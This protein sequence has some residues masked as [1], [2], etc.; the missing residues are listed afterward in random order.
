MAGKT[1]KKRNK[2]EVIGIIKK[3]LDLS[4]I[5]TAYRDLYVQHVKDLLAPDILSAEEYQEIIKDRERLSRLPGRINASMERG[6]WKSVKEYSRRM[7]DLHT[8]V[9]KKQDLYEIG[10]AVFDDNTI[11]VSPFSPGLYHVA[12]IKLDD[13]PAVRRKTIKK[14][15]DIISSDTSLK[16][17]Y[18]SRQKYYSSINLD[19]SGEASFSA[20]ETELSEQAKQAL[21]HGDIARLEE[22][23]EKI[24]EMHNAGADGENRGDTF[25]TGA[26][27]T[28]SGRSFEFSPETL[29]KAEE[30]GLARKQV[31][32]SPE[33]A[34][35]YRNALHPDYSNGR[36]IEWEK[37]REKNPWFKEG[38]PEGLKTRTEIYA[39]HI[40]IN[41]C[42]TRHLPDFVKEDILVEDFPET[43][44]NLGGQ[45]SS[46]MK[47]LG[48]ETR[49]GL[50][51]L[52]IEKALSASA[53]KIIRDELGLDP[54]QFKL[55]CIPSDIY[56]RLGDSMEWGKQKL[57][58]HF[59]GYEVLRNGRFNALVGGDARFGGIYDLVSIGR[60]YE[61]S[62]VITR[63]AVVMRERMLKMV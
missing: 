43:C 52:K 62:N 5:D 20:D 54:L 1:E 42:G 12:G 44:D 19:L 28:E 17:L 36:N 46:L 23:S 6:D 10:K 14:I 59:D 22:I 7:M 41:S 60:E 4:E 51:R 26:G 35:L 31:D 53:H 25:Q 49:Q 18:T 21:E 38:I 24:M 40:L 34:S 61:S 3:V 30:L 15:T 13:L 37:I 29:S 57:W 9:E 58:T 56:L 27:S 11:H 2:E 39:R 45:E 50:S 48:L 63:F 55:V 32:K 33:Y 16:D 47:L 8:W